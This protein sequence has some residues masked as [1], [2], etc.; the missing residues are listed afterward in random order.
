M[1]DEYKPEKSEDFLEE[2]LDHHFLQNRKIFLWGDVENG[3]VRRVVQQLLYLADKS[4]EDISLYIHSMGGEV[5]GMATIMDTIASLLPKICISTIAMGKCYSAAANILTCGT[6]G[7][8][9]A[10]ELSSIMFHPISFDLPSDFVKKQEK[11][12]EY[13]KKQNDKI[14]E[15]VA[16]N[17]KK[18]KENYA[19]LIEDE[20]WLSAKEAVKFGAIDKVITL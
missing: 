10:T 6:P 20:L 13:T 12:T 17:C 9:Y 1:T 18:K 7:L 8:R 19:K 3:T 14:N 5:E 11:I 2:V 16:R 15:I 4:T